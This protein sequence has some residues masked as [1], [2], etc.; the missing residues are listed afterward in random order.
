MKQLKLLKDRG[1]KEF[2]ITF[3]PERPITGKKLWHTIDDYH[4]FPTG[5]TKKVKSKHLEEPAYDMRDVDDNSTRFHVDTIV[6]KVFGKVEHQGEV[7]RY[8]LVNMLYHIVYNDDDSEEYYHNEV[9]DQQKRCLSKQRQWR[10][11]KSAK[12]H[13]NMLLKNPITRI[14]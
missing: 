4:H 2:S 9:R 5:T 11:L 14:M 1:V 6:F 13:Q 8:D 10:K 3:A 12:I 7:T